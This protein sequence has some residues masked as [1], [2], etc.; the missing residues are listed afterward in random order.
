M[1]YWVTS[2]Y[3]PID[4]DVLAQMNELATSLTSSP[5]M[6]DKAK[7][8]VAAI[9]RKV[10]LPINSYLIHDLTD[11]TAGRISLAFRLRSKHECECAVG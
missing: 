9:N 10:S 4:P 8:M 7:Q 11:H 3:K 5:S 2:P 6:G 1:E